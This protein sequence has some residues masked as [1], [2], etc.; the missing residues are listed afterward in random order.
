MKP[1]QAAARSPVPWWARWAP[2]VLR[3]SHAERGRAVL[4]S[5]L[6]IFCTAL[7]CFWWAPATAV[8]LVA[9]IGASAVLVFTAPASPLAQPWPVVA[10]NTVSAAVGLL[11]A[12]WLPGPVL[13]AAVAVATA[14][15]VMMALRC[16]HP[17]GGAMALLVVLMHEH[18]WDFALFPVLTNSVLLV[19]VAVLY[20][21]LSRHPYPYAASASADDGEGQIDRADLEAVLANYGQVLDVAP[22]ALVQLLRRA[23]GAAAE[24]LWSSLMC[25]DI[26]SPDP[27]VAD[28]K[29][30][31]TQARDRM[32]QNNIKALPV[33]DPSQRVVGIIT[34]T[35]LLRLTRDEVLATS[36]R[37]VGDVMTRQVRVASADSHALD[38][39][40]LFS[41]AGHHHLPIIDD[42]QRL[43]GILTQTDL[44]RALG[45]VVARGHAHAEPQPVA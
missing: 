12:L 40:P 10:G 5:L 41:S 27:W 16:L 24:R 45:R 22:D 4:G 43:V 9:P 44:V 37:T 36:S 8:W 28:V 35:D 39:L 13:A 33:V 34:Q 18:R 42:A 26:M 17:P 6:G 7:L 14:M 2:P 19:L 21:N 32:Q 29:L 1:D 38:L 23:Q 3:T 25:R 31:L 11:C 30:S 20:N 15:A